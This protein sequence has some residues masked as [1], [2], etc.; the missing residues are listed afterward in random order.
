MQDL[1]LAGMH[2]NWSEEGEL[3]RVVDDAGDERIEMPGGSRRGGYLH[4]ERPGALNLT[5]F[6]TALT[7]PPPGGRSTVTSAAGLG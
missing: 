5:F 6:V 2:L 1:P 3:G 4:H 7:V